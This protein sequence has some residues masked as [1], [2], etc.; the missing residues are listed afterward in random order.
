MRYISVRRYNTDDIIYV[1]EDVA[2]ILE[3]IVHLKSHAENV[4]PPKLLGKYI[5]GDIMGYAKSD[6]GISQKVETWCI[7]KAPTEVAIIN[8]REFDVKTLSLIF[9]SS[10]GTNTSTIIMN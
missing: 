9:V 2:V 6:N 1:E 8:P 3:G 5:Q 7:V 4:L 10:Y